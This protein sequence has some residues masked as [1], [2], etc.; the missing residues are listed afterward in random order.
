M[1]REK[2]ELKARDRYA[3]LFASLKVAESVVDCHSGNP[4]SVV[5]IEAEDKR[6]WD[7]VVKKFEDKQ[8]RYQIKRQTTD[9]SSATFEKYIQS[10]DVDANAHYHFVFPA[11]ITVAGAG[12]LR[13]LRELCRRVQQLGVNLKNVISG[14]RKVERTWVDAICKW[15]KKSDLE[16]CNLLQSLSIDFEGFE[17]DF[18]GR[19]VRT[20]GVVFG[21]EAENAWR[22]IVKHVSAVDGVVDIDAVEILLTLPCPDKDGYDK[23]YWAIVSDAE[24]YLWLSRLTGLSD[25]LMSC[26]MPEKMFFDGKHFCNEVKR[27]AWPGEHESLESA[28]N[29]LAEHLSEYLEHLSGGCYA[30]GHGWLLVDKFYRRHQLPEQGKAIERYEQWIAESRN[31]FFNFVLATN[32][33][34]QEVRNCLSKDYRLRG[35]IGIFESGRAPQGQLYFPEEFTEK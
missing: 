12:E 27:S 35:N 24:K 11:Y 21:C 23:F 31:R 2:S 6:D 7:D 26:Q 30:D 9:L 22:A 19:A 8:H 33:Y 16:V 32:Q 1:G 3:D 4:H 14:F 15:T 17:E 18:Q 20:L 28:I 25:C 10:I 5:T 34:F 13:I 29:N